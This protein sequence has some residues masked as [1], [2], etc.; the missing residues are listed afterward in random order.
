MFT[1]TGPSIA[2]ADHVFTPAALEFLDALHTEFF[3]RRA[4]ILS[5]RHVRR[6]ILESGRIPQFKDDTASIRNSDWTVVGT[7]GAPG[8]KRRVVELTTPVTP[9]DA[10]KACNSD[11]DVW[12]ADLED[13]MSPTW[14]TVVTAHTCLMRAARG[15][16]AFQSRSGKTF[17][18]RNPHPPTL[19]VR[20]RAWHMPESHL[21]FTDPAGVTHSASAALVDFGLFFFHNTRPLIKRNHG[22]YFYLPKIESAREATLWNDVFVFAQNYLGV[23]TGTI[24]ATVLIE[25]V[26]AAFQM[27]EILYALREHAVGLAAGRWDYVGSLITNFGTRADFTIPQRSD[28]TSDSPF[29]RAFTDLLVHTCHRRGAQALGGLSTA[30]VNSAH[31]SVADPAERDRVYADK[32]AEVLA[33]FDGTWIAHRSLIDVVRAA[34]GDA[35]AREDKATAEVV[36]TDREDL[37]SRLLTV[38]AGEIT[39]DGVRWNIRVCIQYINA[40]LSGVGSLGVEG[41]VE[42]ASTAELA[43]LQL[44]QWTRHAVRLADGRVLSPQLASRLV[45]E[46][47]ATQPRSNADHFDE[48]EDL[49]RLA[50]NSDRVPEPFTPEA[51]RAHL[52]VTRNVGFSHARQGLARHGL[53]WQGRVWRGVAA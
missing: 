37:A 29:I 21:T 8:L 32:F 23:P 52:V 53:A 9:Q 6:G 50:I 16:F 5:A 51:Y 1:I 19:V 20:P 2:G 13:G 10:A 30:V 3:A 4:E 12:M 46:E 48:A 34:Y 7:A 28:I 14:S 25:S 36:A 42:D 31:I 33:G 44:W 40:W 41:Y 27:D 47:L 15:D 11:A 24:R 49:V 18:A 43:R 39:E 35:R 38:P 45:A 17:R 26:T 22:P